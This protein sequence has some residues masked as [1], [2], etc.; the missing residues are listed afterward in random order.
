[1]RTKIGRILGIIV[2][3]I[4]LIIFFGEILGGGGEEY[5]TESAKIEGIILM[6]IVLTEIF[7][8]VLSWK[9][10]KVGALI[11]IFT[12]II[13]IIFAGVTAGQ[14][15]LLAMSVSGLPFLIVGILIY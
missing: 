9:Y 7:G 11:V 1:M 2:I 15:V 5:L 8:F 4:W 14:N 13:F 12:A 10:R 3:S 6:I